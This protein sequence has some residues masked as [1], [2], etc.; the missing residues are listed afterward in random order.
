MT[1]ISFTS[2]DEHVMINMDNV[3]AMFTE[4]NLIH[5]CLTPR[6]GQQEFASVN[7][8]CDD[9]QEAKRVFRLICAFE[10]HHLDLDAAIEIDI[11]HQLEASEAA[12]R[13]KRQN[14]RLAE[15]RSTDKDAI[16]AELANTTWEGWC[17]QYQT[18]LYDLGLTHGRSGVSREDHIVVEANDMMTSAEFS[19]QY[20]STDDCAYH[21]ADLSV[22]EAL[23][24]L[25]RWAKRGDDGEA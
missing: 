3:V 4:T 23:E 7:V 13:F 9:A 25:V 16:M 17:L 12:L 22:R 24:A 6:P 20:E 19:Y 10:G 8:T 11:K 14:N 5:I 1:M 15:W 2:A 21:L 18:S